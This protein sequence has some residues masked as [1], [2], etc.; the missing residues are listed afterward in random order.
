MLDRE[1]EPWSAK[2][3]YEGLRG[4]EREEEEV[5]RVGEGSWL[6]GSGRGGGDGVMGEREVEEWVRG[7]RDGRVRGWRRREERERWDEGRVGGWR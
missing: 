7:W 2:S 4:R 3:L 5:G 6:D 1:L